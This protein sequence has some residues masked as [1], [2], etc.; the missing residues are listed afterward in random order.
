MPD[1]V[2][3]GPHPARSLEVRE[4]GTVVRV[5][6]AINSEQDLDRVE[7]DERADLTV[8]AWVGWKADG[9]HLHDRSLRAARTKTTFIDVRLSE[10][11]A[12]RP[13]RDGASPRAD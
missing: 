10:N 9:R 8:T 2:E 4:D 6:L 12:G 11:L 3:I 1:L 13:V 7:V 5:H